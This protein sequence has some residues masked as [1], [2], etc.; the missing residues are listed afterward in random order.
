MLATRPRS[1]SRSSWRRRICRGD[2]ATGRPSCHWMSQTTSA[3][4]SSHG[5]RRSVAMS[6]W[7]TKSPYP[8]SQDAIS[9]PWTGIMSTS[10]VS[11]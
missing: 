3:V 8:D 4:F 5:M 1:A 10:T 2:G 7:K 9:K 6:G 11:R